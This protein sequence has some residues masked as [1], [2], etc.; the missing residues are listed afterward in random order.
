M[1]SDIKRGFPQGAP[2]LEMPKKYYDHLY[3]NGDFGKAWNRVGART[4]TYYPALVMAEPPILDIGCGTGYLAVMCEQFGIAY[5]MG[6]DYSAEA[7]KIARERVPLARFATQSASDAERKVLTRQDYQTAVL[8]EVLE[9]VYDDIRLLKL[10]PKGRTVV[11][12]VPNFFTYG[13]VRWFY[14]PDEVRQRYK[15][16]LEIERIVTEQA[17]VGSNQWFIFKGVRK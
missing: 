9:H 14:E 11:A 16:A 12:S 6:I 17:R 1:A 7:I 8:L 4:V 10:I 13:H 2:G 15:G 3:A 5:A